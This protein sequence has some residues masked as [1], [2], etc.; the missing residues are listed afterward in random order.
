M[1]MPA[2]IVSKTD[3]L[4]SLPPEWP[5]DLLPD[6]QARI[7]ASGRK[8]V[9][10]DDDPTG[11]QTV[12]DVPVLTTWSEEAIAQELRG[13]ANV[14]YILTNSRSLT[15]AAAHALGR[16]IG[17][18]IKRAGQRTG[19]A[20]E[21]IS[22][23]DSTLRGHFPGEVE[24]LQQGL[25]AAMLPC[26]LVPF[27]LEGG[28]Y[29]IADVHYV[30]EGDRL[31]P[32]SKTSYARDAVFGYE[33]SH[34]ARWIEE[35]TKGRIA[36]KSIT[37]ITLEDL[38]RGGPDRI[39]EKLMAMAPEAYGIV[40]AAAY[41]DL[42][43]LVAG[44]LQA[45]AT[46]KAFIFRTAAS[47]V[48]VRSGIVP[49]DLLRG[50]E[51]TAANAHGGL[52]VVGSY[53][54]KTTAQLAVL[55]QSQTIAPIEISVARLLTE[56][57][58]ETEIRGA[59]DAVNR[60]IRQGRDTVVFTSRELVTSRHD[61]DNLALGQRVSDS[62]IQIVRGLDCQPRYLVAK[63][64]ITSSDVAT[65]G[66]EVQRAMVMGQ[67]LPG[68]PAWKL[69]E[70]ARYPG[71]AYIIFPGNVGDDEGLAVIQQRLSGRT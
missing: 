21:V 43:V 12:H 2:T 7:A 8:I 35:K 1:I 49:R 10:L 29:T 51:L 26:L 47:F 25:D 55:L 64:G 65:R 37:T 36:E 42:E 45:E 48:R 15:T 14:F 32:A 56:A 39:A 50:D 16:E 27:F 40:N 61:E 30:A 60:H 17:T 18:N 33:H 5:E 71:M 20:L 28:R 3:Q 52:F 70:E 11:T 46:G 69:G 4:A 62:L 59:V 68:V 24:A 67:V 22:R 54:P 44:L 6:I 57:E 9:V 58:R 19:V 41:R 63:G 23:S 13:R 53:V 66:L 31:V 34:L 38:R